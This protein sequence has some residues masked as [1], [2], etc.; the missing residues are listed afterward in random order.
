MGG[1]SVEEEQQRRVRLV[2]NY[3][4]H[5]SSPIK[6]VGVYVRVSSGLRAQLDSLANQASAFAQ[7]VDKNPYWRLA[8]MYIDVRSG[9]ETDSRSEFQRMIEDA[10]SGKLDLILTKSIS[11]FG[12]NTEETIIALR[13]LNECGVAVIFDEEKINSSEVGSELIISMISAIAQGENESRRQNQLWSIRK[14]LE[15]GS[16]EYYSR[17][18]YGYRKNDDG[19]L[20]VYEPEAEIVRKI[21]SLYLS[22]ASVVKILKH[23]AAEGIKTSR[24][25]DNWSKL[26]I[27][28]MLVNE[29]YVGDV[30]VA[31]PQ[32]KRK[33]DIEVTGG[34]LMSDAHP[35][36]ISREVFSAVQEER[37]RRSNV[38]T[39][40]TGTHRKATRY[41][42]SKKVKGEQ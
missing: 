3:T 9:E 28:K 1:E 38:V 42:A 12:R 41:S 14:K 22:G 19:Q 21:F 11:R 27:E 5:F 4:R 10:K 18:C 20:E 23:L 40:E 30:R 13:E 7:R 34:Y 33:G 29:K 36:I 35:A 31:K 24:G 15:D 39:D 2:N 25:K 32:G 17:A 16:S 8:D 6:K 37:E 26:A